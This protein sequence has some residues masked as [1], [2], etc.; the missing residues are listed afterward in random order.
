MEIRYCIFGTT[1]GWAGVLASQKGLL[2]LVLPQ[3]SWPKAV[4][5]LQG[6]ALKR[7]DR[8]L[9]EAEAGQ[10]GD[11]PERIRDYLDG[12]MVVFRDT[13]DLSWASAFQ[14]RV[15]EVD[16]FIPYGETR[17][18]SWVASRVGL[19][20]APRAVGQALAKNPLPIIIPCHRVICSNGDL[21]GFSGG[22]D[23]KQRLLQI[24]A[25]HGAICA[26][27]QVVDSR[28]KG[29]PM[30]KS[31]LKFQIAFTQYLTQLTR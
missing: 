20:K 29:E 3:S 9:K 10:F 6:F 24:E 17:T 25:A 11:L 2:K 4:S 19:P 5:P 1:L 8:T 27:N 7:H 12:E 13:L 26:G 15:W 16:C 14:R 22:R 28:Q 23:W 21:G 30:A 18:Y 31:L